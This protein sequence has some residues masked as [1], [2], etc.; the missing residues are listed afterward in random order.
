MNKNQEYSHIMVYLGLIA[1]LILLIVIG[2]LIYVGKK[3]LLIKIKKISQK[4]NNI[5]ETNLLN[6]K[7]PEDKNCNQNLKLDK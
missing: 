2:T 6:L 3:I 7:V 5:D 1:F 4:N